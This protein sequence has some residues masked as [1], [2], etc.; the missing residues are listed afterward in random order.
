MPQSVVSR[1]LANPF[2][3]PDFSRPPKR[4]RSPACWPAGS[5]SGR[6]S[7]SFEY[8]AGGAPSCMTLPEPAS[9]QHAGG[10]E[11]MPHQAQ[12][13]A[14]AA[15]GHRTFLLADEP[16]LGKTA[17][18]LLAAQ[19]ADAYPLLVVVP[20]V[21]KT[22]WA[23]E[24]GLWTPNRTV[25]VIHGDGDEVDGFA[26]IV[27]VNY[28]V[29]DRHVGWLGD[30]GFRG[31][32]VDEAHF[33]KN[34]SLA[35]LPA[36]ARSSSERIR[37]RIAPAA[38]DGADRHAAD[39][40]HRGLPRDLAVPRLDRR[41]EAARRAD[42]RAGGDRADPGRPRLLRRR[43]RRR[44]R[45]G[46]RAPAQGR[47][48]R[49]HPRPPHR[50]PAGRARRRGRPLDPRRPSGSSPRRLVARYRQRARDA[51]RRRRRRRHRPRPRPPG[52]DAGSA[53]T[54]RPPSPARTSSA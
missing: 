26:D 31:M 51:H 29:L 44:D 40:R 16:G 25:T 32:V 33:I 43:P 49:R 27:V 22:N 6:C 10:R 7:R 23:R 24:V 11:L 5:C 20:N 45:H 54:R 50:R 14:A 28:E 12:V 3:A 53:R 4:R 42:G 36:R 18:A 38:A 2:L 21:V 30:H 41:E 8:A 48:G 35:A 15:G 9:L 37:A 17:Q 13:V 39:Q 47:R 34:K 1:Q 52:R 46:H 19:A